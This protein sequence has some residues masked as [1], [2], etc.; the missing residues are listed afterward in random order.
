MAKQTC[1][2]CGAEINLIQQQ[3]MADGNYICRKVCAKLAMKGFDFVGGT[4]PELQAHFKQVEEGTAI[5]NKL[6]LKRK[7]K[8]KR[9]GN[10]LVAED[11]GL[12]ARIEKRYKIFVFGKS[13]LASVYR[14]A[15]LF[16]YE[17]EQSS[18]VTFDPNSKTTKTK[19]IH[20]CHYFFWDTSGVSDFCDKISSAATHKS[21]E[22]YFNKLFG[23]QKTIG[24]IGKNWK[25]QIDAAKAAGSALKS[26]VGGGDDT[27]DKA[28][29]ARQA[30]E[31]A[32]YGDRTE[33]I[34]KADAALQAFRQN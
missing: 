32:Q 30:I 7:P 10:V 2:V 3:K 19:K 18:K 6:F 31:R 1:A 15:D 14:I 34:A 16:G 28:E 26:A 20:Y 21:I 12:I 25:R 9:F 23:I 24:N 11:I 5:Y 8:P 13:V 17:Y 27:D 22:K 33:W 29:E 4:L